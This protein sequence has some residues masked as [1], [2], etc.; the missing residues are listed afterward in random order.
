MQYSSVTLERTEVKEKFRLIQSE[1]VSRKKKI[2]RGRNAEIMN[3]EGS[4]C[5]ISHKK[6]TLILQEAADALHLTEAETY[7]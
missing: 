7:W 1:E 3:C 5:F 6:K 4:E 2:H